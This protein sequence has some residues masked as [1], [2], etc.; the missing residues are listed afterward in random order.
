MK[1]IYVTGRSRGFAFVEMMDSGEA[2][3]ATGALNGSNAGGR[4]LK[5]S[6]ARPK[7]QN[8]G[9]PQGRF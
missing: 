8:R 7:V 9:A 4:A 3:R 5:V 6:E 2:D 1:R